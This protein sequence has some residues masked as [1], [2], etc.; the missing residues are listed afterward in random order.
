MATHAKE[1]QS[2]TCTNMHKLF[3]YLRK[4]AR[5]KASITSTRKRKSQSPSSNYPIS[6]LSP[7]STKKRLKLARKRKFKISKAVQQSSL[8]VNVSDVT[9]NELL[10]LVSRIQHQ[11]RTE[12]K[13]LLQE[14]DRE[15]QGEHLRSTWK[16]D[17]EDR[18]AFQRDQRNLHVHVQQ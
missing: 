10:T 14:A 7:T 18:V 11:S 4:E 1:V 9:H 5:R 13:K 3:S 17:V 15:G 6:L 16:Q 2:I 8:N 12:L